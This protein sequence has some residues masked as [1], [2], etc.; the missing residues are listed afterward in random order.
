MTEQE[1]IEKVAEICGLTAKKFGV[2]KFTQYFDGNTSVYADLF[3]EDPYSLSALADFVD[4]W[5][6][7]KSWYVCYPRLGIGH[8]AELRFEGA[9]SETEWGDTTT[10]YF[11]PSDPHSKNLAILKA[12]IEAME[13]INDAH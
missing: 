7:K 5:A 6:W 13:I 1:L 11:D 9:M 8:D 3:S 4:A 10:Y 12:F 2:E